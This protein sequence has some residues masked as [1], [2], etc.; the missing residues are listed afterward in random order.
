MILRAVSASGF[1]GEMRELKCVLAPLAQEAY[2]FGSFAKGYAVPGE[3]DIDLLIV[4]KKGI[5]EDKIYDAIEPLWE[6]FMDKGLTLHA[7]IMR[8]GDSRS[9]LGIAKK[10][11]RVAP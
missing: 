4:P 1:S 5:S 2:I 11:I 8:E 7:I 6:R 3:S 9:I 10:G